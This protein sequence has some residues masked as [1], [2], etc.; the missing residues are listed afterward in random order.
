MN[1]R[2]G[3]S[4]IEDT[5]KKNPVKREAYF[6][7][8]YAPTS[9]KNVLDYK[10][11]PMWSSNHVSYTGMQTYDYKNISIFW[12]VIPRNQAG[13]YQHFKYPLFNKNQAA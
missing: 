4:A 7:K 9:P 1:E 13:M 2:D 11:C 5:K 6:L 8:C 10:S 12:D 3:N